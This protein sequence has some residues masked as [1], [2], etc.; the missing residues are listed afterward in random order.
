LLFGAPRIYQP[1]STIGVD[2]RQVHEGGVKAEWHVPPNAEKGVIFYVHGGGFVACSRKTH[3]PVTAALARISRRCVLS[4]DYSLAPE[5]PYPAALNDVLTA[6]RWL[7]SMGRRASEIAVA[8]DSAGGNLVLSLA[9]R[10]RETGRSTPACVV[11]FSPWTDLTGSGDSIRTN[12]GRCAMFRSEN[13]EQFAR[14]YLGRPAAQVPEASPLH[15]DPAG[16]PPVLFHVGSTELLLD[17]SRAM[18]QKILDAGG[19]STLT[20]FDDMPHGWQM[21]APLVPEANDSLRQASAFIAQN[22]RI[23]QK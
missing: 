12:D 10:L 11:A 23:P 20:V 3:R 7:L 13:I 8:G 1:F 21:L 5:S 18:H 16:L 22:L 6:Y 14:V 15:A 4:I 2:V 19:E 17:D 9:L